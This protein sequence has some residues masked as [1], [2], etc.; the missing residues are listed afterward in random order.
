MKMMSMKVSMMTEMR[1]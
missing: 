1:T